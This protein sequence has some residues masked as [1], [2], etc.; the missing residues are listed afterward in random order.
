MCRDWVQFTNQK[1]NTILRDTPENSEKCQSIKGLIIKNVDEAII[2]DKI[3]L[4]AK[5]T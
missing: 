5:E 3:V 2:L 1:I 4:K